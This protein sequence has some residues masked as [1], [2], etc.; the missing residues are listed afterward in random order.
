MKSQIELVESLIPGITAAYP[1][2]SDDR[3][4]QERSV[5]AVF[6]SAEG[7]AAHEQCLELQRK[8]N[9]E[10]QPDVVV[11]K[12]TTGELRC[13]I[14]SLDKR[15]FSLPMNYADAAELYQRLDPSLVGV[16]LRGDVLDTDLRRSHEILASK[17]ELPSCL[18][19]FAFPEEVQRIHEKLCPSALSIRVEPYKVLFYATD[20]FFVPHR[21]SMDVE[22]M[23]GTISLGLPIHAKKPDEEEAERPLPHPPDDD[24]EGDR[25]GEDGQ[26][27]LYVGCRESDAS[28]GSDYYM[29]E[30]TH[31]NLLTYVVDMESVVSSADDSGGVSVTMSY[32]AWTGDVLHEVRRVESGYRAVLTYK[33]FK[34]GHRESYIPAAL[35]TSVEADVCSIVAALSA[36]TL[37]EED[38]EQGQLPAHFYFGFAL[39][40]GY[41]PAGL[42]PQCLKGIDAIV[43]S[44]VSAVYNTLLFTGFEVRSQEMMELHAIPAPLYNR[45][46]FVTRDV[47]RGD[48]CSEEARTMMG[49]QFPVVANTVWI[50]LGYG[51][52]QGGGFCFGNGD[53]GT[54]WWYRQSFLLVSP[55]KR[56]SIAA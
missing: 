42:Q 10:I 14:P 54:D 26:L 30:E 32:G 44:I 45:V 20:D 23:F 13:T 8:L 34:E 9:R 17:V 47:P 41:P 3:D 1:A 19:D 22:N 11:G 55:S 31:D 39:R 36:L 16:E 38:R 4:D 2:D 35:R 21:D 27:V 5:S 24:R 46:V 50:T 28:V 29:Y 15:T 48:F 25:V 7:T 51:T 43:Y 52:L 6:R 53:C 40:H 33:L 37:P 12:V 49:S 18:K 56:Q